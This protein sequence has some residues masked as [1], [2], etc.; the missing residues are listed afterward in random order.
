MWS[1]NILDHHHASYVC[2]LVASKGKSYNLEKKLI[3]CNW[4]ERSDS[5]DDGS[6]AIVIA[7]AKLFTELLS[8]A[9]KMSQEKKNAKTR[10]KAFVNKGAL[11][12]LLRLLII[13]LHTLLWMEASMQISHGKIC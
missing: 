3:S 11:L 10:D 5:D 13:V 9:K 2:C 7:I 4:S 8:E 6:L 1:S 12:L